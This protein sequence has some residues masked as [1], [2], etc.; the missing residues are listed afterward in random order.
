[1]TEQKESA[2]NIQGGT[3]SQPGTSGDT[4]GQQTSLADVGFTEKQIEQLKDV[5]GPVISREVQ[6]VKDR[7]FAKQSD[8]LDEMEQQLR[9]Y[10]QYTGQEF[11]PR[12]YR[13]MQVDEILAGNLQQ[14]QQPAASRA[15]EQQQAA[16]DN[17]L[18]ANA[19]VQ[20]MGLDPNRSEVIDAISR[21][22]E[23]PE[24]LVRDLTT[25][26]ASGM[27]SPGSQ[28]SFAATGGGGAGNMNVQQEVALTNELS[29]LMANPTANRI[30]IAEIKKQ[31][32]HS[33]HQIV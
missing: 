9:R 23:N 33:A 3:G 10:A 27:R 4:T 6:S 30:R 21:N 20:G 1:M 12:A 25:L 8:R 22:Q 15:T 5:F 13:E 31:L 28:A 17:R 19:L 24:G 18:D 14:Q 7:R 32:G 29:Q 16:A 2:G 11:D 26:L